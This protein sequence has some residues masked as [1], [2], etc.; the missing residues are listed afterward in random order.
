MA[1]LPR[2]D[3]IDP[4]YRWDLTHIFATPEAWEAAYHACE[5]DIRTFS[6]LDGHVAEDPRGVI[7]TFFEME[8]RL[9]PVLDYAF[10]SREADNG[11]PKAQAMFGRVM[12]L[13]TQAQAAASFM[14]PE[15]LAL[16]VAEL[17]A[18]REDPAMA[19]YSEFVRRLIRQKPHT[20]PKEQERLLASLGE[21]LGAPD[22]I[23]STMTSVD[24]HFED[25]ELPD[26]TKAPL[27]DGTWG[28]FRE[29]TDRS[30][31]RQSFEKIMNGYG[32]FGTTFAAIYGASVKKDCATAA[33]RRYPDALAAA[34][35]PLEIP[36]SV[37]ENLIAVIH[38][39]LP[40]LQDY[41]KLRKQLLGVDELHMYDLYCPLIPDYTMEMPY[42]KA[43][44]LV[45]AGLKPMGEDY[46][47]KLREAR[48]G[49]W[50]DVYPAVGK[51]SGAFSS[52]D[53]R[54]VH[55]YV[56]LNHNDNLDSAFT[57]AHELGHSMHSFYSNTS[58][59]LAKADYSL[60]VAEV[61]STCNEAVMLRHLLKEFPEPKA[62]A[63][64]LNHFLEQFRTTCFRQT[65][66]AEFELIAHGMAERGEPLTREALSDAYYKLNQTYYGESCA[67]DEWIANEWMRIPH[68]YRAYY[69]YVYATGLCAA[70]TL[71]ERILNEGEAAVADVRKFLSAGSSVPPI[72]ALKLAGVDMSSPEPVRKA[73]GVFRDTLKQFEQAVK[74]LG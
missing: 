73:M 36:R 21:V 6:A 59:P 30:L 14:E 13:M 53:L 61:A 10:L 19:D 33:A 12:M 50:I 47:A 63:Y 18:I 48:D 1:N 67:V 42:G 58:Q 43:F 65:M 16:D 40:V 71:S 2:R 17:E 64:L 25:M 35:D 24:L 51:S 37:Y 28:P 60:F 31:R 5:E 11:D 26:G 20:L 7:R 56:L 66:F 23:Y 15:L 45:L 62:Q 38:E 32:A 8:D 34:M 29:S 70:I 3:E 27:T 72:E 52:G 54:H 74:Q 57:I 49:G 46:L 22:N 44:D 55:P 39:S 4:K 69:V 68:F 41:L 9:M